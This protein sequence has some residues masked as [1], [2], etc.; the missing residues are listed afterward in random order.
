MTIKEL[1]ARIRRRHN[2][3]SEDTTIECQEEVILELR[4][5]FAPIKVFKCKHEF[6]GFKNHRN[7]KIIIVQNA[8]RILEELEDFM[9]LHTLN[10]SDI[11]FLLFFNG[12]IKDNRRFDQWCDLAEKKIKLYKATIKCSDGPPSLPPNGDGYLFIFK[13]ILR[14][15]LSW[16]NTFL[17]N[18]MVKKTIIFFFCFGGLWTAAY[19][20]VPGIIDDFWTKGILISTIGSFLSARID[21]YF[22][23]K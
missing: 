14:K 3:Y 5:E 2:F 12:K 18:R 15:V 7:F 23:S 4:K 8:D 11:P 21:E 6:L 13:R 20:L 22:R 19:F 9:P 10:N 16:V 17:K 1:K